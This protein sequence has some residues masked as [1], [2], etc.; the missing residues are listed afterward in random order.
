MWV[1]KLLFSPVKK[2]IFCPKT[3]KFG[4][5]LA[6]MVN[7][8]QA[9]QAYPVPC[10]WVSWWLWRAGCISQDTYFLYLSGVHNHKRFSSLEFSMGHMLVIADAVERTARIIRPKSYCL[11]RRRLR[12]EQCILCLPLHQ[13]VRMEKSLCPDMSFLSE[14]GSTQAFP[15]H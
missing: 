12:E 10:W 15:Y 7:L 1:T 8:S 6:F 2:R 9:M 4:P 13:T 11:W 14:P 3:T 5:K